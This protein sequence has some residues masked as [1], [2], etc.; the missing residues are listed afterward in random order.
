MNRVLSLAPLALLAI[1]GAFL[2]VLR[3]S[4]GGLPGVLPLLWIGWLA[5]AG[6][7]A[8]TAI[9]DDHARRRGAS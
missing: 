6:L 3:E 2:V 7:T 9:E 1:S 5:F 8:L 4:L